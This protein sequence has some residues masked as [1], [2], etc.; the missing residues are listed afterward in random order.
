[1]HH[2]YTRRIVIA[3]VLFFAVMA[4]LFGPLVVSLRAQLTPAEAACDCAAPEGSAASTLPDGEAT[5]NNYCS[6]CHQAQAFADGLTESLDPDT[7]SKAQLEKLIGP[8]AHGGVSPAEALAVIIFMRTKAGLPSTY[9][10]GEPTTAA[11]ATAAA[12]EP[13]ATPIPLAAVN[14]GDYEG[15]FTQYCSGCHQADTFAEG[16]KRVADPN[17]KSIQAVDYL[18]GPPTHQ[19]I[20][21][22]AFK[23]AIN[24]VRRLAGLVPL[25]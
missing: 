18:T 6:T 12:A 23:P 8:P 20:P 10:A 21:A 5:F 3:L 9:P 17:S 25:R 24:Y 2:I 4:V 16:L 13:T 15:V 7:T 22:E 14:P 11:A 19:N 1:M